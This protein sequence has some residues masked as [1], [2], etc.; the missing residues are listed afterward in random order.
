MQCMKK[1]SFLALAVFSSTFLQA[2]TMGL[3]TTEHLW[4]KHDGWYNFT[5]DSN[6]SITWLRAFLGPSSS[7]VDFWG[8]TGLLKF[9]VTSC[10]ASLIL[11]SFWKG[12]ENSY[13]HLKNSLCCIS[14]HI[15]PVDDNLNNSIPHFFTD[16]V[17]SNA[18]QIQD[19]IHIPGV[20]HRILL[21]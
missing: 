12:T 17:T 7:T 10:G 9:P 11:S 19:C 14:L 5:E 18:N 13:S 16:I 20:I 3:G 6:V 4:E 8:Q 2:Q 1:R 15:I 21:S